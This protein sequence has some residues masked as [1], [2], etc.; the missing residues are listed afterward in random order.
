M[1][2]PH[3]VLFGLKLAVKIKTDAR[4]TDIRIPAGRSGRIN[5]SDCA[6]SFYDVL[7]LVSE[8]LSK[9]GPRPRGCGHSPRPRQDRAPVPRRTLWNRIGREG[10]LD[11]LGMDG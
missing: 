7:R 8:D 2:T 11:A 3:G 4:K 10:V 1:R 6:Y 5:L 9:R